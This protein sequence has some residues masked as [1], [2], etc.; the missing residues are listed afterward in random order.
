MGPRAHFPHCQRFP[1]LQPCLDQVRHPQ[2]SMRHL[3]CPELYSVKKSKDLVHRC[4][5]PEPVRQCQEA[6]SHNLPLQSQEEIINKEA[7]KLKVW[8]AR[9]LY[10]PSR[11]FCRLGIA[12]LHLWHPIWPIH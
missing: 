10:Q 1:S 4:Q 3:Q 7:G 5:C 2:D 6:L 11:P 12:S 9:T 8:L